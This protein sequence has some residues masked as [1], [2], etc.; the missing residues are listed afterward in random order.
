M[1]DPDPNTGSCH[2]RWL[3]I[4]YAFPPINRSGTHRTLAFVRHL[5]RL[6]WDATVLTVDPSN[7]PLDENLSDLVPPSTVVIRSRWFDVLHWIKSLRRSIQSCERLFASHRAVHRQSKNENRKSFGNWLSRF[8]MTPDSRIGWIPFAVRAGL[9]AIR[10][11]RPDVLYST[12][13]YMS[14]HLVALVLHYCRRIPWVAD[15]RDPWVDNPFRNLGFPM[16]RVWDSL[17][18][19]MVLKGASRIVCNTPT[20]MEALCRRRPWVTRKCTVIQNGVDC[21]LLDRISPTRDDVGK[22]FVFTHS[23]QFYGPRSP[24]ALFAALGLIRRQSPALAEGIQIRLIGD[25]SHDGRSLRAWAEEM[26]VGDSVRIVGRL[27]HDEALSQMA[28]SDALILWG[29][30]GPGSDR[31]I[32]NKLFEYLGLR[33]PILAVVAPDSPVVSILQQAQA[34]AICC[35]PD[36]EVAIAKALADLSSREIVAPNEY[37]SGVKKFDRALRAAE[38]L[39]LFDQVSRPAPRASQGVL[40]VSTKPSESTL[41]RAARGPSYPMDHERIGASF[42]A[43]GGFRSVSG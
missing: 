7:E 39:E 41:L 19:W 3:C 29:S 5:H 33:R 15:F 38:L 2:R 25:E 14:A 13:P 30:T 24:R 26:G 42:A 16:L 37:W 35:P 9:R 22:N 12:S 4:A 17:L 18:E 27:R 6:G 10:R 32:P 1:N 40:A 43:D 23:G 20:M 36:D 8:L 11:C 21:D 28:G 34:Y 31:Q